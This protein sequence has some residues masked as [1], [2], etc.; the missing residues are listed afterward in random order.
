MI[1]FFT[2][3]G[4]TIPISL[5][6][7]HCGLMCS[8]CNAEYLK[9]MLTK[10]Q[11]LKLIKGKPHYY[12]SALISGGSTA[13]GKV[14]I[15]Q[16][17]R[18]IKKLKQMGL[19]LNF[20]TGFLNKSELIKLK[21]Y[22]DRLSFDFIYDD[23]VIHNVYHLLSK[24]K[25]DYEKTYLLIRRVLGGKIHDVPYGYPSTK[26]VPHFTIGLNGGKV[27]KGDFD[28][29]DELAYLRPTLLVINIF[30]PTRGTPF[31]NC[32]VPSLN[33]VQKV[34]NKAHRRLTQTTMFLGCMRPFGEYREKL[35]MMAYEEGVKGFVKPAKPL[36]ERVRKDGE[37]VVT[38]EECCALI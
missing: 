35:D 22:V 13:E 28:T 1:F 33:D 15:M 29:I 34:L 18:F 4:R 5:T 36:V 30:V 38:V 3:L 37:Q 14:P 21:P 32:P 10:E 6:G 12:T 31:E 26:T 23:D 8:H 16:H 24:S 11:A 17:L 19:K 2:P 9:G 7:T 25:E 20:H 27:G